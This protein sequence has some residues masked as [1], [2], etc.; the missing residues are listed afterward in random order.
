MTV[1]AGHGA[2]NNKLY[3]VVTV[4]FLSK[5]PLLLII[6]YPSVDADV[7]VVDYSNGALP[8]FG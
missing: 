7:F 4:S 8:L 2:F 3:D 1:Q 6:T 5:F